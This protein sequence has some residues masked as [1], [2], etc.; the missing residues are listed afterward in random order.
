M[1]HTLIITAYNPDFS[2]SFKAWIRKNINPSMVNPQDE[3]RTYYLEA[4]LEENPL[5]NEDDELLI[6]ELQSQNVEYVEF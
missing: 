5:R 1:A 2:A 3:E 6:K 4:I